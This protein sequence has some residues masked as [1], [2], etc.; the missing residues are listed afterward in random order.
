MSYLHWI[1]SQVGSQKIILVTATAVIRDSN[2]RFLLQQRGDFGWWGFSGGIVELDESLPTCAVREAREET[3]LDVA[4]TRLIG[5]YSSPDFDV[6][7]PNGDQVQQFTATF[8]CHVTGGELRL[9]G[10]ETTGLV[11]CE[12]D[13]LWERLGETAVWYRAMA[14]DC[15]A[16]Q[17]EVSFRRGKLGNSR[18]DTPYFQFIRRYVGQD[19]FIYPAAAALIVNENRHVLLQR[20]GDDGQWGLPGGGMELGERIDQTVVQEILEE[21]GL[22]IEPVRVVGVYSDDRFNVTYPNGDQMKYVST[23]FLCRV[24]GGTLCADGVESLELCYFAPDALPPLPPRHRG[25]I[26]D[27]LCEGKTAVF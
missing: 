18:A 5:L 10:D 24:V 8:E 15:L 3:G 14:E 23:L 20:R 11:W 17:P 19:R 7:Y 25:R 2:G 1:R 21:T 26:E 4:V 16:N 22:V 12:A 6:L 9:D 13:E 27:G